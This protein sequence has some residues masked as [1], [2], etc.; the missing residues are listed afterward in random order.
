M[1]LEQTPREL[2][3]LVGCRYK[4]V[5]SERRYLCRKVGL[6]AQMSMNVLTVK[7]V[8]ITKTTSVYMVI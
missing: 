2:M 4:T 5:C 1:K 3:E 6:F 8:G 7:T